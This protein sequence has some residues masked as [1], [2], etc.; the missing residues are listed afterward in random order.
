MTYL[1]F[2]SLT[3]KLI[4]YSP[5][6]NVSRKIITQKYRGLAGIGAEQ[7][8]RICINAKTRK[9]SVM[10]LKDAQM[11]IEFFGS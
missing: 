5:K 7:L 8:E 6:E 3:F 1:H 4:Y 9:T 11:V 10:G 2:V